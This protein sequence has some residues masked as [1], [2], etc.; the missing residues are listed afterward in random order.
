M[1]TQTHTL[2][3]L[4]AGTPETAVPSLQA[5]VDSGQHVV[6][7]LTRPDAPV[8]RRRV[9]T[10]S[11]VAQKAEELGIP[12]I[13]AAR[14]TGEAGR[15]VLEQIAA[16][17]LDIAAVVAYGGLIPPEGLA[18]PRLGWV[19]LHFSLLPAYR[20]AA[21]VQHAVIAGETRT[22]A[23][24]FQ[25]E[26]GLDTGPIFST[27]ERDL[28]PHETA[29]TVLAD[30]AASGA[31]LLAQTLTDIGAGALA[32][33]PQL[34]DPTY[35]PKLDQADGRIDP[36]ESSDRVAAR[37]NGVTPEPGAW[38]L[39]DEQTP[40]RIKVIGAAPDTEPLPT[41]TGREPLGSFIATKR[42]LHLVCGSGTVRLDQVQPAGKKPM[43]AVDW[44]RGQD[45]NRRFSAG[46]HA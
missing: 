1:I 25:L 40:Q 15:P 13:K 27:L 32:A 38:A 37:I 36:A 12:I 28:R 3:V 20:G 45:P 2:R 14:L 18:L 7:V 11:P 43:R 39:T 34:G 10:P 42:S 9:M 33:S 23:C 29:G 17:E 19:N 46:E 24:V 5:L 22:G 6:A 8:G 31:E 21:P 4:F 41:A 30:L 16:L 35:A 44:F 26:E